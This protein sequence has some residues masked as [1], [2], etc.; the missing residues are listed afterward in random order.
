M[1]LNDN[2]QI[3][4]LINLCNQNRMSKKTE[5]MA[6]K[7]VKLLVFLALLVHGIGHLQG[8]VS[9][10][11]VKLSDKSTYRSWLLKG[12]SDDTNRIICITLYLGAALFGIIAALGFKD[13][14]VAHSLWQTFALIAAILS[15]LCL[16]LFPYALAMF[17]NKAGAI[18][19]NLL[20]YYSILFGGAFPDAAF[21]D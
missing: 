19:M 12:S 2:T 9:G 1:E 8:V 7:T 21:N 20:I 18:L 5:I 15:T 14:I 4:F 11:G 3:K 13:F 6:P 10:F 16:V 17:F